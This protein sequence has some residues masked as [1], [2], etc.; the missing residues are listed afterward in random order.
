MGE[1]KG[2]KD[3]ARSIKNEPGEDI[4]GY[5]LQIRMLKKQVNDLRKNEKELREKE[6]N[7]RDIFE[8]VSQG[9]A[10]TNLSGK[11]IYINANLEKIIGIHR[12][13]IIGKN[14][15]EIAGD[16]L[17]AENQ[18]IIFPYLKSLFSGK[19][20]KPFQVMYKDK[21]L[22][23]NA[24]INLKT[25]SLTGTIN[26][27]TERKNNENALKISEARLRR[28]ELASGS[29]NWE[30]HLDTGIIIGSE[31]AMK[32][33][34]IKHTPMDYTTVKKVP[35]PEYREM[36]DKALDELIKN[37]KPYD[38][39][40]K[41]RNQETGEILDIHSISEY[42]KDNHILFGSIQDI[43]S[44]KKT[45][46]ELKIKSQNL[47]KLLE[48]TMDLL[49]TVEKSKLFEKICIEGPDLINLKSSAIYIIEGKDL[50]LEMTNPPLP[51][52]FPDIFRKA[53][54]EDNPHIGKTITTKK[55]VVINDTGKEELTE[56]ERQ[57]VEKRGLGS[58]I[59]VPLLADNEVV[60]VLIFGTFDQAHIY[61]DHE[62]VMCK[63]L[64]NIASL[65]L[66]NSILFG[67]LII[68]KE[69]AEESD[70]LKSAFLN[71]ISHEIRTPLNA[72]VGFTGLLDQPNL[73]S[74]EKEQFYNV[75]VQSNNQLLSIINDIIN[76][77]Q[78]ESNQIVLSER[79][80]NLNQI[81]KNLY[82]QFLPEAKKKKIDL[83]ID[84]EL[85]ATST[86]IIADENKLE[87]VLTN[88]LN[89]ALK[90]TNEGSVRFGYRLDGEL[91][92]FFVRDT[93][94]GITETEQ[95]KVFEPFYQV[96]RSHTKIYGGTGLGL[97]ISKA[98]VRLMG[99]KF[100]LQSSPDQGSL[101]S[102]TLPYK[103]CPESFETAA[104][105]QISQKQGSGKAKTILIAEAEY[106]NFA[107]IT[108]MLR[109]SNYKFIHASNGQEAIDILGSN[110]QI[111]LVIMDLK[112]P[113][114]SGLEAASEIL[115]KNSCIP[116]IAQTSYIKA[117][118]MA[119]AFECGCVDYIS[120][121][122][123]KDTLLSVIEKYIG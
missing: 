99:G 112:L 111:D 88:L 33:Y 40:F 32:L 79:R 102:F 64:S 105:D 30:L 87:Q 69:K 36:M 24:K 82:S 14:I 17:D 37:N 97:P 10:Y 27:I 96:E 49:E 7:L 3:S 103:K 1:N 46:E 59:Y 58:I 98:Y 18:S 73:S 12:D 94:I 53:S 119:K 13:E 84:P 25:K 54:L 100:S 39:E 83:I 85:P 76:I 89:N 29:G 110:R 65:A 61:T 47:S 35:L 66:E 71:N 63:A 6:E 57:I 117:D 106:S 113:V 8:T 28:A 5:L 21:I 45:E 23:V 108:S 48:F 95:P 67:N 31:G 55:L 19:A 92:E 70:R 42:D 34:G 50:Y 104:Q 114:K 75:I 122:Y 107:L 115:K 2:K 38:I 9:I 51:P 116:V 77:S 56:A 26:D 90:F 72:I 4:S 123:D 81:I 93:G 44:P 109:K 101:F 68:A 78:I 121:P 80:T 11:V 22:E 15:L 91:L 120:K 86:F 74:E 43:T 52:D 16:L 62:K 41:I 118:D 20:V 60:A